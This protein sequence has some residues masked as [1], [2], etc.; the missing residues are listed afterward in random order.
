M[1]VLAEEYRARRIGITG[2]P[3]AGKSTLVERLVGRYRAAGLKV[4][5]VAVDPTS[6]FTGGAGVAGCAG[7]TGLTAGTSFGG[8]ANLGM[9]TTP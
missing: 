8:S 5:V 6:T 7:V 3:G 1:E 4:A 2:P 9:N